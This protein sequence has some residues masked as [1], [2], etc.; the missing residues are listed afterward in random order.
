MKH[1]ILILTILISV[2]AHAQPP[3]GKKDRHEQIE[4]AKVAFITERLAMTDEQARKFWPVYNEFSGKRRQQMM[5]LRKLGKE[6]R[7]PSASEEQLRQ[8]FSIMLDKKQAIISLEKEYL[9]RFLAII[10]PRQLEALQK[11][12]KDFIKMLRKR[13]EHR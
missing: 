10:N 13:M 3:H 12:E 8:N 4:K 7:N 2:F 11:A 1:F 6:T 5:E 9:P